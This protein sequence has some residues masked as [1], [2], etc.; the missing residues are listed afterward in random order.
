ML[1]Q[2]R[3][4]IQRE[5]RVNTQQLMREF[6]IDEQALLPMLTFWVNKQVI[7]SSNPTTCLKPCARCHTNIHEYVFI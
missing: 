7:A 3:D 4:F 2:L 1:L 5:R 6:A